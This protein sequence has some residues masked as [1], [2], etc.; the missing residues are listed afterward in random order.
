MAFTIYPFIIATK[1]EKQNPVLMNHETIHLKQE[2]ELFLI[3][4]LIL[5]YA[6]SFW[7]LLTKLSVRKAYL[8][9]MFEVEAYANKNDFSY[10][11]NRK[12]FGWKYITSNTINW[13][14]YVNSQPVTDR[15]PAILLLLILFT[16][17]I[18]IIYT[19]FSV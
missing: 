2:K 11:N 16:F 13:I 7:I 9:N 19:I 1:D 8:L 3:L 17:L 15:F 18:M 6:H 12:K 10:S 4:F 5:F 14:N